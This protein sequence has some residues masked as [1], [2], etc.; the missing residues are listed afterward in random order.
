MILLHRSENPSMGP[1]YLLEW[2]GSREAFT[3]TGSRA[4]QARLLS[5]KSIQDELAEMIPERLEMAK[6]LKTNYGDK[7]LGDVQVSH[8]FG[9]MRGLKAMLWDPSVLDS[10]EGATKCQGWI[11]ML[12]ESMFW[13]LLTGKVPNEK[14]IEAFQADL[15][16]RST[17]VPNSLNSSS[18][19]S[20]LHPM[21]Q[22]VMATAALNHNSKFAAA[23]SSGDSLDLA[24]MVYPIAA[25]IYV[26]KYKGFIELVRLYNAFT[27]I[28]RAVMYPPTPLVSPLSSLIHRFLQRSSLS[29]MLS[30]HLSL[31]DLV[32]SALSDPFLSYSAALA[33]LA[34]PLHGLANQEALRFVLEMKKAV[35][36]KPSAEKDPRFA[37]LRD[38]VKDVQKWQ[39]T[40]F[41]TG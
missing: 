5:T 38:L 18:I 21:T 13:Y 35:G 23:Y 41:P 26:T 33:G 29:S 24:A 16:E 34:G 1:T 31:A 10:E 7:K 36:D 6:N 39:P 8:V 28:T 19:I 14:Q 15:A 22:F 3:S 12:P 4:N 17:K 20:T 40:Q 30:I 9:G 11:E 32:G 27:P 2:E 25:R 37:A